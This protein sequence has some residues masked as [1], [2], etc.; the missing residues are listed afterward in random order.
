MRLVNRPYIDLVKKG[1][2]TRSRLRYC[3][4]KILSKLSVARFFFSKELQVKEELET[5]IQITSNLSLY[6]D[7]VIMAHFDPSERFSEADSFLI[8]S[9]KEIG[10]EVVV[11]STAVSGKEKHDKMWS[12]I[13][14]FVDCLITRPNLGFDFGS[15]A[16]GINHLEI[17]E[18]LRGRLILINNSVFGPIHPINKLLEEWKTES[19]ILGVTSSNEFVRHVQSYF[20]GF[21]NT[22][23]KEDCFS[24]FWRLNFSR[25]YKW[26]TIL[27][28]EMNW[29]AYF[30]RRGF[31]IFVRHESPE[32]FYRNPLTF[33]WLQLVEEGM[34]FV[35]KS[36]FFQNYD[37][38]EMSN[39]KSE[40]G[41]SVSGFY[42][43]LI[44]RNSEL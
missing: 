5:N 20:L 24:E 29:G 37:H 4:V 33:H 44:E 13:H 12:Q 30:S 34:P 17:V 14:D 2:R 9:F 39:W 27:D 16:T 36:L 19:E 28:F 8:K 21:R 40:L 22:L 42:V 43:N 23:V 35:K 3:A 38:I 10:F 15:W 18:K 26:K 32:G 11:V 25:K 31:N 41:K 6:N 1:F 7:V